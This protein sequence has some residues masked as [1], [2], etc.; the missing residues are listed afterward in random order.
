MSLK[1]MPLNADGSRLI[2]VGGAPRSGTSMLQSMMNSH[3]IIFGGPEFDLIPEIIQL[4]NRFHKHV[5]LG[6]IDLFCSR[7]DVDTQIGQLMENLL[8]PA[9]DEHNAVLLS[10]KTPFNVLVFDALLSLYPKARCIHVVRDPRAVLISM[11]RVA[12]RHKQRNIALPDFLSSSTNMVRT[13]VTCAR[14]GVQ[15]GSKF[16]ER[17]YTA[18]YKDLVVAPVSETQAIC[19]FLGIEWSRSMVHPGKA[20]HELDKIHDADAGL[21]MG[22]RRGVTDPEPENVD[23]WR[24]AV[25]DAEI[26][27]MSDIFAAFP[28]FESMGYKLN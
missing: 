2:F 10:E 28:V 15:A 26:R 4:R 25:S 3:P 23:K 27:K 12:E 9:A 16:P 22:D 17:V 1:N 20:P 14:A 11:I 21:W 8:L 6:R 18:C 24:N 19:R 13:I 5:D 7:E